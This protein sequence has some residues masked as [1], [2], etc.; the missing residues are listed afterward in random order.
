[1][2]DNLKTMLTMT[3]LVAMIIIAVVCAL[4]PSMNSCEWEET[5][6]I[7]ESGDTLWNIAKEN[8]P[9]SVDVRDW[10]DTVSEMNNITGSIHPGQTITI[11]VEAE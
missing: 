8:C 1:M 2:N 7:V 9:D 5:T 4:Q 6:Y 10:I 3:L 11:L